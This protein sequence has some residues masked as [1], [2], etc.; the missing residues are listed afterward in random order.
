MELQDCSSPA[1]FRRADGIKAFLAALIRH[2]ALLAFRGSGRESEYWLRQAHDG[3]KKVNAPKAVLL[4][5]L[6][7]GDLFTQM[8][9]LDSAHECL[10]D[11][12]ELA[13][14]IEKTKEGVVMDLSFF[15]LHGRQDLWSDAF[16]TIIRAEG[17][18]KRL[19]EPEFVNGLEKGLTADL[20]ERLSTLKLSM[21][22]RACPSPTKSPTT[23][24]RK[25]RAT[26]NGI[27]E[28]EMR[29]YEVSRIEYESVTFLKMGIMVAGHK[30]YSL[31]R[32]GRF[33][34]GYLALDGIAEAER[35]SHEVL[36]ARITRTKM[37]LREVEQLLQSDPLLC[38]LSES[39][40]FRSQ[41]F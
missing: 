35:A 20:S 13:V 33:E 9:N 26:A 14:G 40:M 8:C 38:V 37:L 32:Q 27:P 2:G 30:A 7:L 3:A 17:R 34:E 36:V 4:V 39:G 16:R 11:A 21:G 24:K 1:A 5:N 18:L 28:Y 19:L 31:A 22:S 6:Y 15:G 29:A 10:A 25:G 41:Y 12:A 23:S